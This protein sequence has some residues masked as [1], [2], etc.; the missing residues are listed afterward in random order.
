MATDVAATWIPEAVTF[1]WQSMP[2]SKWL[3]TPIYKPFKGK[4]NNPRSWGLTNQGYWPLTK[5]DDPPST[6]AKFNSS[7]LQNDGSKYFPFG[8]HSFRG[9]LLN[10]QFGKT[11]KGDQIMRV[12]LAATFDGRSEDEVEE[13]LRWSALWVNPW[14]LH[15][16]D[17]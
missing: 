15:V 7:P 10:F 8:I 6:P 13:V 14:D 16:I 5:W 9:E 2:V 17:I 12:D 11:K 1:T 3:V 4:G